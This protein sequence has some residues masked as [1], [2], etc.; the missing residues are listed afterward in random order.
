MDLRSLKCYLAL[1][2]RQSVG[3]GSA[4]SHKTSAA[5]RLPCLFWAALSV[6]RVGVMQTAV[7]VQ[8]LS[9]VIIHVAL[10]PYAIYGCLVAW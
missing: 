3:L 7:V 8:R 4:A 6:S 9:H 2:R 1:A 10:I 5:I